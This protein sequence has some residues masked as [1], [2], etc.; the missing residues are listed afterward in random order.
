MPSKQET[1]TISPNEKSK[2]IVKD[3][4]KRHKLNR[5]KA[6]EKIIEAYPKLTSENASLKEHS[7]QDTSLET[8]PEM[9]S[10]EEHKKLIQNNPPYVPASELAMEDVILASGS[11]IKEK[12][13]NR[14]GYQYRYI[15]NYL[16]NPKRKGKAWANRPHS[17]EE[18]YHYADQ[19][20]KMQNKNASEKTMHNTQPQPYICAYVNQ[21]FRK[22]QELPCVIDINMVC[23][24]KKCQDD[25]NSLFH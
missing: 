6:V 21:T 7:C 18:A 10:K 20:R 14:Q 2:D 17:L 12:K 4:M 23:P 15:A 19:K 1:W 24:N 11:W 25:I 3:V 16:S 9:P 8:T 13:P 5:T 22:L